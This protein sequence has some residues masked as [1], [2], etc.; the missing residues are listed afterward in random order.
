MKMF[1]FPLFK[2]KTNEWKEEK[3]WKMNNK[4]ARRATI[5]V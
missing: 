2:E 4:C 5:T 3:I 1:S